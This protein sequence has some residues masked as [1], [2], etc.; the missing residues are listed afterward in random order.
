M[1]QEY[2]ELHSEIK[3]GRIIGFRNGIVHEYG[4][5]DYTR[6]YLVITEEIVVLKALFEESI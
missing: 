5:T 6:V 4:E 3:W 1:S 2:R